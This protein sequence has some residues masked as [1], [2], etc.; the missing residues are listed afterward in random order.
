MFRYAIKGAVYL[1][2]KTGEVAQPNGDGSVKYVAGTEIFFV[3][4]PFTHLRA[5]IAIGHLHI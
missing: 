4:Q 1:K 2:K 5:S 3:I